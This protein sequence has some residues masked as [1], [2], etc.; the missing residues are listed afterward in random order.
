MNNL[1]ERTMLENDTHDNYDRKSPLSIRNCVCQSL[2]DLI[3]R[4]INR[5]L[6]TSPIFILSFTLSLHNHMRRFI[7][8]IKTPPSKFRIRKKSAK[9]RKSGQIRTLGG[10]NNRSVVMWTRTEDHTI[11]STSPYLSSTSTFTMSI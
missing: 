1:T 2:G 6:W 4:L 7:N 10:I 9:L 11:Y 8:L 3:A 5:R